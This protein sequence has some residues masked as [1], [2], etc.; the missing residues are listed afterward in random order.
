MDDKIH[1]LIKIILDDDIGQPYYVNPSDDSSDTVL[2]IY[3]TFDVDLF[4]NQVQPRNVTLWPSSALGDL[5]ED[6]N[7]STQL[8]EFDSSNENIE[9]YYSKIREE[10]RDIYNCH[11]S[12]L[13]TRYQFMGFLAEAFG[14]NLK[15]VDVEHC[16]EAQ[17]MLLNLMDFGILVVV[18]INLGVSYPVDGSL[19]KISVEA[20]N[21]D[22]VKKIDNVQVK[23]HLK[24]D[25]PKEFVD[26]IKCV[27]IEDI[28]HKVAEK[29]N[30][31]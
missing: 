13:V 28:V 24:T 31:D 19:P 23:D 14:F 8:A 4:D 22:Q 6:Y 18:N 7:D 15:Y 5:Y 17:L 21:G 10:L 30:F 12:T 16:R 29:F 25:T 1:F 27:L 20:S 2:Q 11:V 9:D 3:S 26:Y